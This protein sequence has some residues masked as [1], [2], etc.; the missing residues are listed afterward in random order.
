MSTGVTDPSTGIPLVSTS[1]PTPIKLPDRFKA[2]PSPSLASCAK[3][4]CLII[5][6]LPL[7]FKVNPV[8]NTNLFV[9]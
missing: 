3:Y 2:T 5:V 1:A 8:G 9:K 6:F 4:C 7:P